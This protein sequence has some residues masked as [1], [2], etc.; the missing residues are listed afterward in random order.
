MSIVTILTAGGVVLIFS[1]VAV[2]TPSAVAGIA[3]PGAHGLSEILYAVASMANNNGSAF[4]GLNANT[5]FYTLLGSLAMLIGRFVPAVATL[6]MAGSL[7][8]KKYVPPSLGTLPTDK[9]PFVLWL[10]LV[11][12]IVG[13]LTF[14]PALAL[15]PIAEHLTM[16]GGH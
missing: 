1:G 2:I 5:P 12:L 8:G 13:A 10:A 11:I 4:A 15:G 3:N 16:L 9:A 6:A 14:F 7:A